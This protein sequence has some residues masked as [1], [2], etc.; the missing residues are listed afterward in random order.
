MWVVD[1][2]KEVVACKVNTAYALITSSLIL[3][4]KKKKR[5]EG[6]E[7]VLSALLWI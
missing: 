7:I 4:V 1:R 2:R 6:R 5:V 3:T